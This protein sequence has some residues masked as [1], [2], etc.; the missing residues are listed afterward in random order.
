MPNLSLNDI[1]RYRIHC[2]HLLVLL[3]GGNYLDRSTGISSGG[4]WSK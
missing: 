1:F 2:S 3:L 4:V